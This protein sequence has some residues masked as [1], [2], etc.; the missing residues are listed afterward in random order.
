[1][2]LLKLQASPKF[3]AKVAIPVA[4]G[5]SVPVEFEFKHRTAAALEEF[6]KQAADRSDLDSVMETATGWELTDK[7]NRENVELLLQNYQGAARAIAE[8]Y[9]RELMALRLGN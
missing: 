5:P 6:F 4:G 2:A 1:M 3:K 8:T 7:F 9:T